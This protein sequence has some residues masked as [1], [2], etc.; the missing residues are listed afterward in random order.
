MTYFAAM[1][2]PL[3]LFVGLRYLRTRRQNHFISFISMVSM[4]G[5]ALGVAALITV[6]S[7]MNGFEGELRN[8]ILAMTAH[9]TISEVDGPLED[10]PLL[11]D[12]ALSHPDVIGAA[13]Y[14]S[15]EGM[16]SAGPELSGV[17]VNGIDPSL[18]PQVSRIDQHMLVG[19]LD[20]LRPGEYGMVIGGSLARS[21]GLAVGDK[22]VL[23]IS[24]GT[25]TP[26]G[27][28]P[29]L[30]R[31]TVVGIFE[32]GMHEYDQ[33]LVLIE[34]TDAARLYGLGEGGVSG[35][36]LKLTDMFQAPQIVR[37]VA[38][39]LGGG[40]YINDWTRQHANFFRA[41]RIEK[42]VMFVILSLI[43]LV[44]AFNIVSTLVMVVN[45]KE[46]DIAILRTLGI[47]RSSIMG[48]FMVQGTMI[49]LIGTVL[50]VGFGLLLALNVETVLSSLESLLGFDLFPDDVYYISDLPSE[51][52][53]GDVAMIGMIAF[54]LSVL[55]T[56]Y[57]ALRA[58]RTQPAEALRY[59]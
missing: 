51:V 12:R 30:R 21:L 2:R 43:I 55:S 52:V 4:L 23:M 34:R 36:R 10:W 19:S 56:L 47:S 1:Y 27:I 16:L 5:I 59:E 15:G 38:V 9:A 40:V 49:G 17:L 42:T 8:R 35:I 28:V 58:S 7:V 50:G 24:Q 18:E 31:F 13:P 20:A 53:P 45:D 46:S 39:Q 6:L 22:A 48:V 37:D 26:A 33:G 3:E 25:V 29:R 54:L 32:V 14:V 44:G 11:R 57:P 41:I